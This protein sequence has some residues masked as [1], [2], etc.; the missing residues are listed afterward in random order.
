MGRWW[1]HPHGLSRVWTRMGAGSTHRRAASI[2]PSGLCFLN[3]EACKLQAETGARC[4]CGYGLAAET[5]S[6]PS[7]V[8]LEARCSATSSHLVQF[9]LPRQPPP[10]R[11]TQANRP[12]FPAER[13]FNPRL[14]PRDPSPLTEGSYG[15]AS[16]AVVVVTLALYDLEVPGSIPGQPIVFDSLRQRLPRTGCRDRTMA[17]RLALVGY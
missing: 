7:D 11:A 10:P 3:M 2:R 4:G 13:I 15:S 12:K 14:R 8:Q 17:Q 1:V 9:Q 6:E 16:Y 5:E